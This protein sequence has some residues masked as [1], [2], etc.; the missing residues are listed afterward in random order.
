MVPA[1]SGRSVYSRL[2]REPGLREQREPYEHVWT[3]RVDECLQHG[4]DPP[5]RNRE[6]F[7]VCEPKCERRGD[8]GIAGDVRERAAGWAECGIG[9]RERTRGGAVASRVAFE[10]VRSSV[11]GAGRPVANRPPAAVMSRTVVALRT[12]APMPQFFR[13]EAGA[14]GRTPESDRQH[15]CG[16]EA[17]GRPVPVAPVTRQP[18]PQ[19]DDG[20]RSFG[21]PSGGSTPAKRSR[22]CGRRK[23]LQS[24]RRATP[25]QP[26]NR[27]AQLPQQQ[28]SQSAG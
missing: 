13:S 2:S 17:P 19:G 10:P 8:G 6:Q 26:V 4:G 22:E 12:P 16:S 24:R 14:G 7:C 5:E 20:F 27:N 3:Y 25:V 1:G 15:W 28:W 23:G 18:Q 21:Q 9:S 11:L